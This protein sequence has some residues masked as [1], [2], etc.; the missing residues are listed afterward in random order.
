MSQPRPASPEDAPPPTAAGARSTPGLTE[1][2]LLARFTEKPLS[3]LL[4]AALPARD[5]ASIAPRLGLSPLPGKRLKTM[6]PADHA[7]LLA[8]AALA[9]ER[10][11]RMIL[12]ALNAVLPAPL[13]PESALAEPKVG[14]LFL[15]I[16]GQLGIELRLGLVLSLL[17]TEELARRALEAI[18][19][20]LL[21]PGAA[22]VDETAQRIA[23]LEARL[24]RAEQ[25][26]AREEQAARAD[27]QALA[28]REQAL[29]LRLEEL[30]Q[31]LRDLQERLGKKNRECEEIR[32]EWE[33]LK[34]NL[35][36]AYRR[37]A[38]YKSELDAATQATPRETAL[39][40][41]LARER[42][43]AAIEAAK[44]EI[45]EYQLDLLE[46][47]EDGE[48]ET[49]VVRA[50]DPV[51]QRVLRYIEKVGRRPRILVVGG[52]GKQR[53]HREHDFAL[54]K[55]RLGLEGDWRF[56]DYT[57]WHRELPRLRNDIRE[58][59]DLVFVLHWNRTTFVQKMHDEA[60][61]VNARVRT[62]PYRGFLSLERAIR[63]EV[64]R[65]V[66]EEI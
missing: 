15:S 60:R 12:E 3:A 5:L 58:R 44:L 18:D 14:D 1:D 46:Q 56:A 13:L 6:R 50:S 49:R 63:E 43:R 59:F 62:V 57:S 27:E 17:S 8:R 37:A 29:R 25:R 23:Q 22:R 19:S 2:L 53:S 38:Q 7:L 33:K 51:P 54:L 28:E 45:L 47:E 66:Q 36:I 48:A 10:P 42:Q 64:D 11:R 9:A 32:A 21:A 41:E 30:Q 4:E 26:T 24:A 35:A 40:E 31:Q 65:F 61:A 52:A 55:E 39:E 16:A 20:G 34:G